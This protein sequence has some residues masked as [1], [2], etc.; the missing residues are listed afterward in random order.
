LQSLARG[1]EL[2]QRIDYEAV[3]PVEYD[4]QAMRTGAA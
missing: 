3:T 1:G 4:R 2:F